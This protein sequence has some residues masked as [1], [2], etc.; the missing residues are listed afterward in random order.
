MTLDFSAADGILG[1]VRARKRKHPLRFG[2]PLP[3]RPRPHS[4]PDRGA[5]GPLIDVSR[6]MA[7]HF[8][9]TAICTALAISSLMKQG[10][11]RPQA[12]REYARLR[13]RRYAAGDPA[14]LT[15]RM[16]KAGIWGRRAR[17]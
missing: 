17:T 13:R 7:A 12:R 1:V 6:G 15:G 16:R 14:G 9:M 5:G 11:S 2:P 3:V 4:R 8:E 10:M